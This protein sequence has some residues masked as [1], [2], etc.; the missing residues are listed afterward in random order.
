MNRSRILN[1]GILALA[2]L[3]LTP[4]LALAQDGGGNNQNNRR[5]LNPQPVLIYTVTGGTLAGQGET[6]ETLIV[7]S[8]GMAIW[9]G[10]GTGGGG[11]GGG[12]GGTSDG[13]QTIQLSQQQINTL[14][15]DLRRTG[16]FRG[17]Q[18]NTGNGGDDSLPM[19]TITVFFNPTGSGRSLAQTFSFFATEGNRGRANNVITNF[20][21]NNFGDGSGTGQ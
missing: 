7:Y 4:A 12:T 14:L 16:A 19:T 15:R 17:N 2:L 1:W 9:A 8:N 5:Q 20:I 10:S 21:N 11:T 6:F 3:L 18:V 13:I